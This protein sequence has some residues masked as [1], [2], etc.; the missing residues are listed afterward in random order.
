MYYLAEKKELPGRFFIK[1]AVCCLSP[2]I[3]FVPAPNGFLETP[4]PH[5][6]DLSNWWVPMTISKIFVLNVMDIGNVAQNTEQSDYIQKLFELSDPA[7]SY[8]L[9]TYW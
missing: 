2:C 7:I 5:S 3:A 9:T 6:N 1:I 8:S 4:R